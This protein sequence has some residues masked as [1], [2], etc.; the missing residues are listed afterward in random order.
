MKGAWV[1]APLPWNPCGSSPCG[2]SRCENERARFRLLSPKARSPM[3]FARTTKDERPVSVSLTAARGR[4]LRRR[5]PGRRRDLDLLAARERRVGG[6]AVELDDLL[7]RG[8]VARR[9]LRDGLAAARGH[10]DEAAA[11]GGAA[12]RRALVGL[13]RAD[14]AAAR[15]HDERAA[16]R[17]VDA[18]VPLLELRDAHARPPGHRIEA[19]ARRGVDDPRHL[20]AALDGDALQ[21]VNDLATA[22]PGHAHRV[23]F[24]RRRHVAAQLRVEAADVVDARVREGGEQVEARRRGHADGVVGERRHPLDVA[25]AVLLRTLRDQDHGEDVGHVVARLLRDV[26]VDGPEV[27]DAGAPYR[28]V[29]VA[30]ARVVGGHRQLPVV[31]ATVEPLQVARRSP[32]RLLEAVALV[33]VGGLAHAEARAG[34]GDELPEAGGRRLRARGR[35]PGALHLTEP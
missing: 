32:R 13:E 15:G 18:R 21:K 9:D 31:V 12:A 2:R 14:E 19:L 8:A 17:E 23:G 16:L 28:A 22:L 26:W 6:H 34:A 33:N 10:R 35:T 27:G 25:E 30:L 1:G 24:A 11:G 5:G 3:S 29:N 7:D 4:G 20:R